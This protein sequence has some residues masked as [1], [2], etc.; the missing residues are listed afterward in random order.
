MARNVK[1][2]RLEK[3]NIVGGERKRVVE[4]NKIK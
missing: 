2:A 4:K 3:K 1:P